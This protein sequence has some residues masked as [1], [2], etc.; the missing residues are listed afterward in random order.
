M[1]PFAQLRNTTTNDIVDNKAKLLRLKSLDDVV[2]ELDSRFENARWDIE[3]EQTIQELH[4]LRAEQI[5][6]SYDYVV[7]YF[8]GGADSITVLNSFIN[9]NIAI[10][11]IVVYVNSNA[12][13]STA[14]NGSVALNYLKDIKYRGRV[15]LFDINFFVLNKIVKTRAWKTFESFSGLL[16]S[17]YRFRITFY[18]AH[19]FLR[20]RERN[21]KVAHVFGGVFP[22][23]SKENDAMYSSIHINSFMV[24]STDPHNIQF[25]TTGDL[26]ELHIKHSYVL[27]KSFN[28]ELQKEA[29]QYKI[30]IRDPYSEE[31]DVPKNEGRTEV[32]E[33]FY[34]HH[35]ILYRLYSDKPDFIAEYDEIIRYFNETQAVSLD[36]FEKSFRLGF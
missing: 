33:S 32:T 25:F 31:L 28:S 18:E 9:N 14:V 5:R 2:F 21:G 13:H 26:P 20:S 7:L 29:R 16:H 6:Q 24:S 17:F 4:R 35:H 30:L 23:I 36:G 12:T 8:S 11:E 22:K 1:T 3:P 27:S 10:D 15:T 34:S 19:K